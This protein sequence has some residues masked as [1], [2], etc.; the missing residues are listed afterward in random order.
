[1]GSEED[2]FTV[3]RSADVFLSASRS[4]A[5]SNSILEAISQDVPVVVSNIKGTSWS[6][7][8]NRAFSYPTENP[9]HCAEAIKKALASD[10]SLSNYQQ[11]L[12]EY[13]IHRWCKKVYQVYQLML[14]T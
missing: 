6:M 5:F 10:K 12:S 14:Q 3:H 2:I 7:A 8:Y 11:F 1:M 9:I 13:D 4:E